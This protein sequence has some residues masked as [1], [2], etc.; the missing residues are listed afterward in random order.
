M[1]KTKS[2]RI[3]K[4][5]IKPEDIELTGGYGLEDNPNLMLCPYCL[6]PLHYIKIEWGIVAEDD[7]YQ[8]LGNKSKRSYALRE[9]GFIVYCAECGDFIENFSKYFYPEDKVISDIGLFDELDMEERA[10]IWNCLTQ[11][12]QKNDFESRYKSPIF[13]NLKLKIKEYEKKYPIKIEIKQGG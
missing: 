10:E 11:W 8:V 13:E 2:E 12:N 4:L 5:I 3:P 1:A 6:S 9:I 7:E